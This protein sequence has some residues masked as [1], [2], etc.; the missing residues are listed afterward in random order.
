MCHIISTEESGEKSNKGFV[1]LL[2][3]WF[4]NLQFLLLLLYGV[5]ISTFELARFLLWVMKT[6]AFC[7]KVF[8][9]KG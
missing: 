6:Q 4:N 8:P 2:S 1:P 3:S 5:K 9:S 7:H